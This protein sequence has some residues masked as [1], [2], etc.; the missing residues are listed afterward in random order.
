[1]Q[2]VAPAKAALG[3]F[4]SLP[5][6]GILTLTYTPEPGFA[7]L[8]SFTYTV[9]DAAGGLAE[10]V[11]ELLVNAAPLAEGDAAVTATATPVAVTVLANDVDPEGQPL[12]VVAV[13]LM[14]VIGLTRC[15]AEIF[16]SVDAATGTTT[17]IGCDTDAAAAL[18]GTGALLPSR[19]SSSWM[20]V[21][22]VCRICSMLA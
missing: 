16:P 8:D 14:T 20:F 3:I 15:T 4:G 12:A 7:G 21:S 17:V 9:Q 10:G 2:L 6:Y 22:A 18:D 19:W 1:M 11:V 13:K 5:V